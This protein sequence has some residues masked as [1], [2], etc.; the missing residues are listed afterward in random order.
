MARGWE[1]K[2]VEEQINEREST[3]TQP[4][5]A[6]KQTPEEQQRS[7]K[8]E[9]LLLSRTR[10]LAA[11]QACCDARYRGHLERVLADLD[12]QLSNLG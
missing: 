6:R 2:S 12:R 11:L 9:G 10:T 3:R 8:R 5:N 4:P 7:V 1:S